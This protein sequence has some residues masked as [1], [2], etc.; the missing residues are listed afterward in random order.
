MAAKFHAEGDTLDYTPP[1]AMEAGDMVKIGTSLGVAQNDIPANI[2]GAVRVN[3]IFRITTALGAAVTLGAEYDVVVA[4][5]T[6]VAAAGGDAD[7]KIFAA[8]NGTANDTEIPF[9]INKV[10]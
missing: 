4:S 3:G 6:A 10:G 1:A 7:I 8:A 9:F 2:K 5:G